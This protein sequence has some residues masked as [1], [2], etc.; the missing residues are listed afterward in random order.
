MNDS[1]FKQPNFFFWKVSL[2]QSFFKML[3][4]VVAFSTMYLTIMIG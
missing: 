4:A 1:Y 3:F 2:F